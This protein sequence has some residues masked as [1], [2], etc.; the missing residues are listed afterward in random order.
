MEAAQLALQWLAASATTIACVVRNF[1][2]LVLVAV[3][4][5]LL[6]IELPGLAYG[7]VARAAHWVK[8]ACSL[9]RAPTSFCNTF[10][11]VRHADRVPTTTRT[12][13]SFLAGFLA[14][15]RWRQPP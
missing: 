7:T 15:W 13:T 11:A 3:L 12:S 1:I 10:N 2:V 9:Q 14:T 6:F 4:P 8:G 5:I